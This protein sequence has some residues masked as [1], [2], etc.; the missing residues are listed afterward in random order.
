MSG[1]R[2]WILIAWAVS[3]AVA[4]VSLYRIAYEVERMETELAA[5]H[6]DIAK[7]RERT[8]VLNAEWTYLAR[9]SRIAKLSATHLP[10]FRPVPADRIARL[11]DVPQSLPDVLDILPPEELAEPA[12]MR[13]A[14]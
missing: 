9:P 8:H 13:I 11:D 7:S 2:M 6:E 10:E 3:A 1:M 4:G 14:P 5:L 12:A